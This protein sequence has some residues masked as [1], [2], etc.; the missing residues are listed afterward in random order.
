MTDPTR[1]YEI[2]GEVCKLKTAAVSVAVGNN[3]TVIAAITGR[4]IRV[5]G[6]TI[7]GDGGVSKVTFKN[8]SGGAALFGPI[9]AASST[10]P[11]QFIVP[12]VAS[13]YFETSSGTGLFA[14]IST[15]AANIN[16]FYLDYAP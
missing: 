5:M 14:D 2:R 15:T 12:I 7:Q 3:E 9:T 13:G 11:D 4:A 16:V 6:F 10:T 8:G 1:I